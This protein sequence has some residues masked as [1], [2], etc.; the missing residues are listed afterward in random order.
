MFA[1]DVVQIQEGPGQQVLLS[2]SRAGRWRLCRTQGKA[3][4]KPDNLLVPPINMPP[5]FV[6]THLPAKC[7]AVYVFLLMYGLAL[8]IS[9]TCRAAPSATSPVTHLLIGWGASADRSQL[10]LW[11]SSSLERQRA[12]SR[13]HPNGCPRS[14]APRRRTAVLLSFQHI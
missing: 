8:F 13:R 6:F 12:E 14:L 1:G 7:L 11:C 2:P 3:I 10:C 4:S 9:V 5:A